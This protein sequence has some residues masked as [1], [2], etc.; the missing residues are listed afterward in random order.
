MPATF[1]LDSN[2]MAFKPMQRTREC[3]TR[4]SV[5]AGVKY[6][7]H[8]DAS[9]M[10]TRWGNVGSVGWGCGVGVTGRKGQGVGRGKGTEQ[11]VGSWGVCPPYRLNQN[12]ENERQTLRTMNVQWYGTHRT[13][14]IPLEDSHHGDIMSWRDNGMVSRSTSPR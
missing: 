13:R 6:R 1:M 2:H 8:E 14:R 11:Q 7:H 9:Q 5:K 3:P 4:V 10:A 12:T